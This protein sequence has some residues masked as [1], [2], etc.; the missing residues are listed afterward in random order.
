MDKENNMTE[1]HDP[2]FGD[3]D[4]HKSCKNEFDVQAM[5]KY[6]G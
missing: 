6:C 3:S 4:A 5:S 1:A 2:N